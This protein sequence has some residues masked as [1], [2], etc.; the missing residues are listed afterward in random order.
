MAKSFK[1]FLKLKRQKVFHKISS[2]ICIDFCYIS[3]WLWAFFTGSVG[4]TFPYPR[5]AGHGQSHRQ[6]S[7]A[8]T[9]RIIAKYLRG[10]HANPTQ[11][12]GF[13]F[14]LHTWIVVFFSYLCWGAD[15]TPQSS[16]ENVAECQGIND[17][18]ANKNQ[19]IEIPTRVKLRPACSKKRNGYTVRLSEPSTNLF[20]GSSQ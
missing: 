18:N 2:N 1:A 9:A 6:Q 4:S 14:F 19:H 10:S 16:S 3:H 5:S 20:T 11:S 15:W 13:E 17:S 8:L 12:T 7:G